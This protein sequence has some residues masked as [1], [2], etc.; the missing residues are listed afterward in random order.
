MPLFALFLLLISIWPVS[1]KLQLSVFPG[2]K[3]GR[4]G[5]AGTWAW[6]SRVCGERGCWCLRYGPLSLLLKHFLLLG[7]QENRGPEQMLK[8]YWVTKHNCRYSWHGLICTVLWHWVCPWPLCCEAFKA[9]SPFGDL[10]TRFGIGVEYHIAV[11][12]CMLMMDTQ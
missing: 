12:K 7:Q 11:N 8:S 2:K 4:V 1:R 9:E 3:K 10:V 6:A 5:P